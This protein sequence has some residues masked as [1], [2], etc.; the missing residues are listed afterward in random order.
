MAQ[1]IEPGKQKEQKQAQAVSNPRLNV[2]L[3][4]ESGGGSW[5]GVELGK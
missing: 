2:V 3:G 5:G 1:P 4:K